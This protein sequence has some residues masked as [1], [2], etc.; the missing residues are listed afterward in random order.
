MSYTV[1][2]ISPRRHSVFTVCSGSD[3]GMQ[4]VPEHDILC[5]SKRD[6]R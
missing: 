4:R 5:Q 6:N 3:D 1:C 2:I